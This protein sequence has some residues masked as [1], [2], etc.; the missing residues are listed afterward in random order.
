MYVC[1]YVCMYY[2]CMYVFIYVCMY[3]CMYVCSYVGMY[4]CIYVCV[5][6]CMYVLFMYVCMYLCMY[7]L[8]MYVCMYVFLWRFGKKSHI[9]HFPTVIFRSPWFRFFR[10]ILVFI[11]DVSSSSLCSAPGSPYWK[12][13]L[14][15][16]VL[17]WK[18]NG[19]PRRRWEV[20][21]RMD[22]QETGWIGAAWTALVWFRIATGGGLLRS[23]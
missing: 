12:C 19:T 5:Y 4:L 15:C 14:Y 7:V 10:L 18:P 2:L 22:L 3:V 6:L 11:G 20:N 16:S 21:I 17:V 9:L 8:C 1:I 23:Y 13:L